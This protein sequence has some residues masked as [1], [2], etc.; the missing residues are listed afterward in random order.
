MTREEKF[1]IENFKELNYAMR[2]YS[3]LR[4][5]IIPIYFGINGALFIGLQNDVVGLTPRLTNYGLLFLT[6]V[7]FGVFF[8]FEVLLNSYLDCFHEEL[9]MGYPNSFWRKRPRSNGW[10]NRSIKILYSSVVACW[11]VFLISRIVG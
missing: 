8:Y 9:K 4:F 6:A 5:L 2:H 1:E 3:N 10:V 7:V 11:W